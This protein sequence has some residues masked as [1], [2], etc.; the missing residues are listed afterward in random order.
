MPPRMPPH[1]LGMLH[2][3][4][5][6]VQRAAQSVEAS[7]FGGARPCEA[8]A[9]LTSSRKAA[10]ACSKAAERWRQRGGGSMH[11]C[12]SHAHR[13]CGCGLGG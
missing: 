11:A 1:W 5:A 4:W 8:E 3:G 6:P 12:G 13:A 10:T 9:V 7:G 2:E